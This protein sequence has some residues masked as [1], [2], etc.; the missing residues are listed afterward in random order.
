VF[1]EFA[2]RKLATRKDK[3]K[4][5][6]TKRDSYATC[7]PLALSV[8]RKARCE[9]VACLLSRRSEDVSIFFRRASVHCEDLLDYWFRRRRF[10]EQFGGQNPPSKRCIQLLVKKLE[11]KNVVNSYGINLRKELTYFPTAV[12][13][14]AHL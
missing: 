7:L 13:F 10:V 11:T 14:L 4:I 2:K 9:L 12:T 8:S 5:I 3:I 1:W 6:K